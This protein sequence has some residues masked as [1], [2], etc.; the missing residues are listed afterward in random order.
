MTLPADYLADCEKRARRFMGQWTGTAGSLAADVIRLLKER[1]ELMDT[2]EEANRSIRDAVAAR[3]AATPADDPKMQGYALPDPEP[4]PQCVSA[5]SP[6]VM[7][8]A[9]AATKA[10]YEAMH[11]RIKSLAIETDTRAERFRLVGIAGRAGSGKNTLGGMIPGAV[12]VQLADPIYA[13][14]ATMLGVPEALLRHRQFKEQPIGWL[15]KSPRQLLQTLGTEWGRDGVASDLW[16][17]I[18]RR[19]I[20]ALRDAG[21]AVVVIADVRFEN[22]ADMIRA[23]GG[24]V[25]HVRRA[26]ATATPADHSSETGV[27]MRDGDVTIDN[28]GTLDD[29][30]HAVAS[31]CRRGTH[32]NARTMEG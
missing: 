16:I 4:A 15:G 7:E 21:A 25:W 24:Q 27:A 31:A 26:A 28:D 5:M 14:L 6:S 30:R 10:K 2:L 9:W 12:V 19:R 32:L 17:G 11:G 8:R 29:L 1:S 22:E 13:G 23:D 3:M 18:A 20:E